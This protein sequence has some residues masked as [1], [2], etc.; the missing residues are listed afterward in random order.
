MLSIEITKIENETGITLPK[1]YVNVITNYPKELLDSDAQEFGLLN[2]PDDIIE[3]NLEVREDGYFGEKWPS[4]YFIIGSNGCGDFY[5][6]VLDAEEFSVGFS[7]HESME[8]N[9][10]AN[11][12]NEFIEKYLSEQ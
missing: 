9:H 4:E 5:V 12:L 8:C 10:Y 6:I 7:D 2:D 3:V 11:N 1:C